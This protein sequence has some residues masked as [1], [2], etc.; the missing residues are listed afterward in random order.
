MV[1][2]ALKILGDHQQIH[3]IFSFFGVVCDQFY[4]GFSDFNKQIVHNIILG[5]DPLHIVKIPAYKGIHTVGNHPGSGFG[6][7]FNVTMIRSGMSG[8]EGYHFRN[9]GGLIADTFHIGN[10]L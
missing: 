2:D 3:G 10:H 1:A 6:H 7:F 4:Q 5:N 9:V 8:K